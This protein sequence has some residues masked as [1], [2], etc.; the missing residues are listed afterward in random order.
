MSFLLIVLI[1]V[2]ALAVLVAAVLWYLGP[3]PDSAPGRMRA[4]AVEA[5]E[6]TADFAAEFRDWLRIGR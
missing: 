1:A 2:V 6:R 5:G 4:G 3:S